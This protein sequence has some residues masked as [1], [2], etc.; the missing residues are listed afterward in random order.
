[1]K[2]WLKS[3]VTPFLLLVGTI[4][5]MAVQWNYFS[6]AAAQTWRTEQLLQ[7]HLMDTQRHIDP[8]RDE[9]NRQDLLN[10]L[11]RLERKIDSLR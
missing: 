8:Y 3:N 11:D 5:G 10:R 1:M 4:I 6:Q 7:Q 9:R 2:E